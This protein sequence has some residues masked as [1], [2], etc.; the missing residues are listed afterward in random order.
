[1]IDVTGKGR[2][3]NAVRSI[4]TP[5]WIV[6]LVAPLTVTL[7]LMT[8][9]HASVRLTQADLDRWTLYNGHLYRSQCRTMSSALRRSAPLFK[10]NAVCNALC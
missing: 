1:L 4:F 8:K 10:R 7:N 3:C 9:F 6:F 5:I 2:R